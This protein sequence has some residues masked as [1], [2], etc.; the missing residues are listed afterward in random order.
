MNNHTKLHEAIK[1]KIKNINIIAY[2]Q[3]T[4]KA[5]KIFLFVSLI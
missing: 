1:E 3:Y 5:S 2:N 4:I